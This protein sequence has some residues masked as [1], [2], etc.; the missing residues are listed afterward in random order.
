M[1][2][3]SDNPSK[4][5]SPLASHPN[6]TLVREVFQALQEHNLA[7]LEILLTPDV[8]LHVPGQSTNAGEYCG[9]RGFVEF[10]QKLSRRA[11]GRLEVH[12][13][14]VLANQ[15]HAVALGI[16]VIGREGERLEHRVVYVLRLSGGRVAECWIHNY[17]QHRVDAFWA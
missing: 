12:V 9:Y 10:W 15:N 14:D 3:L 8:V 7:T 2:M 17:D 16:S 1:S 13:Q 4:P 6:E 11:A 5:Q